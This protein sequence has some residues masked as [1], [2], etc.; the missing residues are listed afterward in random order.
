MAIIFAL[1]DMVYYQLIYKVIVKIQTG[2][3]N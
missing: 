1:I 3:E 2:L